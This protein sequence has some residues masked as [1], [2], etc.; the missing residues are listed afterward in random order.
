[1]STVRKAHDLVRKYCAE[2]VVLHCVSAYPTV[3]ED[4]N[5]SV[6]ELYSKEFPDAVI[7]YSG[8]EMGINITLAAVALGAKVRTKY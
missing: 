4:V 2:L 6:L 8:H 1:M 3:P 7:G 5:L